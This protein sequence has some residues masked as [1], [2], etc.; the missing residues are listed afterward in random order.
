MVDSGGFHSFTLADSYQLVCKE[1]SDADGVL[2]PVRSLLGYLELCDTTVIPVI[3]CTII[4]RHVIKGLAYQPYLLYV[5]SAVDLM[6]GYAFSA[7]RSAVSKCVE[8][9]ELGKVFALLYS[10]ES[11]VPIMMTQAYASLWK[12]TSA[13]PGIGE[14]YWVGTCFFVSAIL[15]T[16]ALTLSIIGWCRLGGKDI[17]DLD[18]K[19]MPQPSYRQTNNET[20]TSKEADNSDTS[21]TTAA[22]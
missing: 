12:A 20:K 18:K 1:F 13:V 10:V 9:D 7:A 3:I 2:A 14:T 6:G 15:T 17:S 22:N 21:T 5:A 16:I 4:A 8:M 11:L 19:P